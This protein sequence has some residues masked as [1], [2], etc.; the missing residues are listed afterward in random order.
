MAFEAPLGV[1]K[2]F[3]ASL[4]FFALHY[5]YWQLTV[6]ASRRALIRKHGCRPI[7]DHAELN[8][9]PQNI[10][11]TKI[12][13]EN[14]KAVKEHKLLELLQGR[15]LRNGNTTH[16]KVFFTEMIQTTEVENIKTMLT[17]HFKEWLIPTR[18]VLGLAPLLGDG[19]FASNGAKWQH[20]RDLLRPNFARSQV[21]D[22]ETFERHVDGL[23]KAIPRDNSTVDLQDLFLQ[24]TMDSATEFLMGESTGCLA[25]GEKNPANLLFTDAVN[26]S[27]IEALA[28]IRSGLT[29][30]WFRSRQFRADVKYIH[31]FVDKFVQQGIEYRKILDREKGDPRAEERYVFLYEVVKKTTDPVQIRSEIL[32]VLLAGRDTTASLLADVFFVL[33]RRPDIW[34]KLRAEIDTL[35]GQKPGFERIKDLKY[36]RMVLNESLRFYPVV[37]F[38]AREPAVDTVL[39]L[40]G[41]DDGKSPLLVP[42]GTYVMFSIHT[43]HRRQDFYGE[44]ADEFKPERW[45]TLRPGW[46]CFKSLSLSL[47]LFVELSLDPE[48]LTNG[49]NSFLSV[50][51]HVS[52]LG[53]SDITLIDRSMRAS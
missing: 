2:V 30:S 48:K 26:R 47:S 49:R 37:P 44:D 38:N 34:A 46:V 12:L 40:G 16:S 6:G 21:G 15:F 28:S 11:G 41:G 31:A 18:R 3:L 8:S 50:A 22:M 35:G 43:L 20:S 10:F 14:L 17:L 42:K 32:N 25:P 33:A 1:F 4:L 36:L 53:V 51:G 29:H 19:I 24:M 13:R 52:A 5:V 7:K 27:Q 23:I 39:P 45:E 9:F